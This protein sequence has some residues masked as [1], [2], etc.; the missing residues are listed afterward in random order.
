MKN[1]EPVALP[2]EFALQQ[3]YPNPF[4]PETTIGFQLPQATDVRINIYNILGQLVRKLVDDEKQAGFHKIVWDAKDDVGR[5]VPSG[6]YIYRIQAGSFSNV[7][8][9][10]LLR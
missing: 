1:P 6:V 7:K 2:T 10:L 4:N 5:S 9:L 3:N 8:K